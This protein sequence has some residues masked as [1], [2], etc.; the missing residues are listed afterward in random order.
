MALRLSVH[1]G[2]SGFLGPGVPIT[3]ADD[4]ERQRAAGFKFTCSMADDARLLRGPGPGWSS[5]IIELRTQALARMPQSRWAGP[6]RLSKPGP[7]IR[8]R[9]YAATPRPHWQRPP[10]A[11][12]TALTRSIAMSQMSE[13]EPAILQKS[14]NLDCS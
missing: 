14:G 2:R 1:T 9:A 6:G 8:P 7:N 5:A 12:P 3:V 11:I 13:W 10:L 4:S